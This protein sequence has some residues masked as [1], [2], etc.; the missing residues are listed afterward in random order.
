MIRLNTHTWKPVDYAFKTWRCPVCGCVRYWDN[1]LWRMVYVM[2]SK[3]LYG[4]P[5][6]YSAINNDPIFKN[7]QYEN[8]FNK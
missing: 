7:E 8:R 5:K 1:S 3:Q 4:A 2:H 6:C